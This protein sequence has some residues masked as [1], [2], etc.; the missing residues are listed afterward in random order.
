MWIV[1]FSIF[2]HVHQKTQQGNCV[3]TFNMGKI[4]FQSTF[5]PLV[6]KGTIVESYALINVAT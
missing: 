5:F 4:S 1:V 2:L 3:L 6:M